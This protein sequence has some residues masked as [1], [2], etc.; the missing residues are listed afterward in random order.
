MAK[1]G[2]DNSKGAQ[3]GEAFRRL[4]KARET[5]ALPPFK[6]ESELT[7]EWEKRELEERG[8]TWEQMAHLRRDLRIVREG[9]GKIPWRKAPDA[10]G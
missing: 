2:P 4:E 8:M 10:P 7:A 6:H 5:W 1:R 3:L 9:F